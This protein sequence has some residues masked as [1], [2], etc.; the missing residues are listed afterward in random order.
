MK[1]L[2]T[3]Y[4]PWQNGVAETA[5][6]NYTLIISGL[7]KNMVVE[8]MDSGSHILNKVPEK[9]FACNS[10]WAV[11]SEKAKYKLFSSL[12]LFCNI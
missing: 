5:M 3:S 6:V 11:D 12:G 8:A 9:G 1:H 7:S 10:V 4:T 2:T